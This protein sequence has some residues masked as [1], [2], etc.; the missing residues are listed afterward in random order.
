MHV[1]KTL[2]CKSLCGCKRCSGHA[3][4]ES[5]RG[6]RRCN[7]NSCVVAVFANGHAGTESYQGFRRCNA[8]GC[9]VVEF[10]MQI[11]ALLS[12]RATE[13]QDTQRLVQQLGMV[14]QK[15]MAAES[16]VEAERR[17]FEAHIKEQLEHNKHLE[18]L[19]ESRPCEL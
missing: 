6:C 3:G 2:Q 7:V 12:A 16:E 19:L 1:Q 15:L 18:A 13:K 4:I 14:R 5:Y 8:N 9:V 10:A 11:L 17:Q